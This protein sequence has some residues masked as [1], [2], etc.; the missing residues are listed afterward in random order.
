MQQQEPPTK[1]GEASDRLLDVERGAG[2]VGGHGGRGDETIEINASA[3][4]VSCNGGV[5]DAAAKGRKTSSIFKRIRKK[6]GSAAAAAAA[7]AQ[8]ERGSS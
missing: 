5:E 7:A 8:G 4:A 3:A 2:D 6:S 1:A